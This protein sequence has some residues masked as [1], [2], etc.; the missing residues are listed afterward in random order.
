VVPNPGEIVFT[1]NDFYARPE[2]ASVPVL[3]LSYDDAFGRFPWDDG[4]LDVDRQPR[5]GTFKA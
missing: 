2:T 4:F 1:A 3:Q 5:P